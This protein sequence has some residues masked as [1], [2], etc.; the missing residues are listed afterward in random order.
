MHFQTDSSSGPWTMKNSLALLTITNLA[1]LD[2]DKQTMSAIPSRCSDSRLLLKKPQL[3]R[4]N[5]YVRPLNG[6]I[7]LLIFG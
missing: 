1:L 2:E 3:K 4:N 7:I 5:G 6:E